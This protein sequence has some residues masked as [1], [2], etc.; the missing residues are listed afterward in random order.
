MNS[1]CSML[2]SVPG[3]MRYLL[4]SS[5]SAKKASGVVCAGASSTPERCSGSF[6]ALRARSSCVSRAAAGFPLAARA[7]SLKIAISS[8]LSFC[9]FPPI[10]TTCFF[11]ANLRVR[12]SRLTEPFGRPAGCPSCPC[13]IARQPVVDCAPSLRRCF[14]PC[15]LALALASD[16]SLSRSATSRSYSVSNRAKS[17]E[18]PGGAP[19]HTT[20][21]ATSSIGTPSGAWMTSF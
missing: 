21:R 13:G 4:S 11:N 19:V 8:R 9:R 15:P 2:T 17:R 5:C 12:P 14:H 3:S 10:L 1:S 7:V 16:F 20:R 18:S 6:E